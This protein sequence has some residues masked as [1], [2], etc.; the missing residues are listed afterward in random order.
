MPRPQPTHQFIH[1]TLCFFGFLVFLRL[2]RRFKTSSRSSPWSDPVAARPGWS[3][4][5][6]ENAS[7]WPRHNLGHSSQCV[8]VV[9]GAGV[10]HCYNVKP[11]S[12][13]PC[14][15]QGVA[16]KLSNDHYFRL[17]PTIKS[18]LWIRGWHSLWYGTSGIDVDGGGTTLQGR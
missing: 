9:P 10:V 6:P 13:N 11:G 8:Q 2:R 14:F 7:R 17:P 5:R 16:S 1:Q 18:G 12:R 3:M 4:S 15:I